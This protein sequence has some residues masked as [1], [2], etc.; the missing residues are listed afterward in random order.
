VRG[1]PGADPPDRVQDPG[2]APPPLPRPDAAG[3]PG[4][5]PVRRFR[6]DDRTAF[7][8]VRPV[9]AAWRRTPRRP[10]PG[11]VTAESAPRRRTRPASRPMVR[12]VPGAGTP[13][14][15][16]DLGG[17]RL[18]PWASGPVEEPVEEVVIGA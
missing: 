10:T 6:S 11:T 8:V 13:D 1:D 9:P 18:L 15:G 16:A 17:D 14:G 2:Q 12:P 4:V 3:V 7:A 5:A